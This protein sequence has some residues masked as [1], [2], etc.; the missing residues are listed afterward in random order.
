MN[1]MYQMS[2][3]THYYSVLGILIVIFINLIMLKK[4]TLLSAYQRKMSLFTP[5]GSMAI[6]GIIFT[7]IVMMAAK[8]L[9]FT[10]EN[11]IMILF[12]IFILVLEVKRLK[13]LKYLNKKLENAFGEYKLVAYKILIAEI[14]LTLSISIWMWI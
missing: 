7:G 1:E 2:I 3:A 4:A 12:S 6:G 5:I 9:D 13:D 11:I 14:V 10:L 8:H